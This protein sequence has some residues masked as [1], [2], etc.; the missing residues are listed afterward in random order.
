VRSPAAAL[1][2]L[3]ACAPAT[4][5]VPAPTPE[6]TPAATEAPSAANAALRHREVHW[7]RTAAEYRALTLQTYRAAWAAIQDRA[8][9]RDPGSWAVIMDA[10]ETVLDNSEFERRIA[11]SGQEFEEWMWSEWVR[12]EEA[13]VVPGADAFIDRVQELGGRVAIVTNRD[14]ELC[15][16]TRRNLEALGIR[17]AV[18]LC[19]KETGEKEGRFRQVQEGTAADGLP[20]LEVLLWVGDNIGDFP[21]LDQA[22]RDEPEAAF[23]DFGERYFVLPNPMYGSW[24]GN[25]WK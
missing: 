24:M 18:V 17:A 1:I 10:D 25:D 11:E 22:L 7:V 6:P 13:G 14:E 3:T 9:D 4:T 23:R 5:P 15:P 19:E 20:P 2:L 21:D 12:E 8:A 16:A